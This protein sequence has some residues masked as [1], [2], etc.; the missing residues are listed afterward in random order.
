MHKTSSED[1]AAIKGVIK[2]PG[3]KVFCDGSNL[4]EKQKDALS[5]LNIENNQQN[6]F[7]QE[8]YDKS[9]EAQ[10]YAVDDLLYRVPGTAA[11]RD[12]L[13]SLAPY[14]SAGELDMEGL[15]DG[16]KI[17][18]VEYP[19][20]ELSNPFL[21]G[22][23]VSLTDVVIQDPYVEAWDF[24]QNTMPEGY[25]PAFY[26]DYTDKTVTDAEGYSF[27]STE[28]MNILFSFLNQRLKKHHLCESVCINAWVYICGG[29]ER[30]QISWSWRYRQL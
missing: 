19:E 2:L 12:F 25:G 14:V 29:Q 26:Y 21:V 6:E 15:A 8:L 10:G 13:Q 16:S 9:K 27:S 11:D 23:F 22:D 24:S 20:A 4:S 7:L 3:L 30:A 18:I 1:V 28:D 5:P 17:V